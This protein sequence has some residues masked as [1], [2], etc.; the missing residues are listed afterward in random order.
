MPTQLEGRP[1]E[2]LTEGKNYAH[3]SIPREDG[4]VQSVIVW[5]HTDDEGNVTLN[6]AEGRTWPENLRRAGTATVT[7][8][9]DGNPYEYVAVTGRLTEDTHEGADEDIDFLAK[10]YI[11]ADSYP[12]RQEGEQR[13]KFTLRPERVSYV[14]QG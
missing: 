12:F 7:A 11:D 1:K 14:N 9:A 3:V 5:A 8:M 4:T 2:I 6:S 10:K 13:V